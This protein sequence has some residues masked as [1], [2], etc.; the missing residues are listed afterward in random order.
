[1]NL[2]Q[3]SSKDRPLGRVLSVRISAR[4]SSP[5]VCGTLIHSQENTTLVLQAVHHNIYAELI[6]NDIEHM[7]GS[8]DKYN[9]IQ[10]ILAN[11]KLIRDRQEFKG[12]QT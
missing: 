7:D 2:I 8:N 10:C 12:M 6:R 11:Q 3:C 9:S 1:M 5:R 4:F